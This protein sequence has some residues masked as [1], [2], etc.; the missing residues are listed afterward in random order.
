MGL[1]GNPCGRGGGLAGN[2]APP[3]FPRGRVA[4]EGGAPP[5][6]GGGNRDAV[7]ARVTVRAGG[8]TWVRHVKGGSSYL[9]SQD[10]R[11]LVGL[12]AARRVDEVEVRWPNA[13]AATQKFG[14]LDADR[15]YRLVE[16]AA[17]AVPARCPPV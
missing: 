15:S 3:A 13:R 12:G 14:P 8:R 7:G 5:G 10:R 1:A 16:G 11:L 6:P 4:V 17:P 9:S 2:G